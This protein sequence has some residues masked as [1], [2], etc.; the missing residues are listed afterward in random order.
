LEQASF[1]GW[2]YPAKTGTR[3]QHLNEKKGSAIP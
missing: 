2:P 3:L 1:E